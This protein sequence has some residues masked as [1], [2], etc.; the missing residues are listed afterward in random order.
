MASP[1]PP[2]QPAAAT[3]AATTTTATAATTSTSTSLDALVACIEQTQ[4]YL[5]PRLTRA[6]LVETAPRE[7]VHSVTAADA[8]DAS[9]PAAVV[10]QVEKVATAAY[11]NV[12][13]KTARFQVTPTS[14]AELAA[15]ACS[16]EFVID[17]DMHKVLREV[18]FAAHLEND[19]AAAAGGGGGG[20]QRLPA[21][22]GWD[23]E[24][25]CA[26]DGVY[27]FITYW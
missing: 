2:L 23:V 15:G 5:P 16:E 10:R 8:Y 4:T 27:N 3:T 21:L 11:G 13:C 26:A 20:K 17:V 24:E 7:T 19:F 9:A 25:V 14:Q 22:V 6:A 12:A 18:V 1:P